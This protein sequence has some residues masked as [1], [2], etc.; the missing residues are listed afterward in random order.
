MGIAHINK[1]TGEIQTVLEHNMNAAEI[2]KKKAIPLQLPNTAYLSAILHDVGKLCVAFTEYITMASKDKHSVRRGS[3][4]HSSAGARFIYD[5]YYQGDAIQKLTAQLMAFAVFS[6]HGLS[7]NISSDGRNFFEDRVHSEKDIHYE[8]VL[9][10][11]EK[12]GM[13]LKIAQEKIPEACREINEIYLKIQKCDSKNGKFYCGVL[14]RILL[15]LV[16]DADRQDT[17]HFMGGGIAAK[18]ECQ[19][20]LWTELQ[21]KFE[22]Y[23]VGFKG[24]TDK[25]SVLRAEISEECY[26]FSDCETGIYCL[27]CP[28]GA[29]KTLASMRFAINH[30]LK[31]GKT[32]IVYVAPF[33]SILEQN[34]EVIRTAVGS[35]DVVLEHHSNVIPENQEEYQFLTE[36]WEA[37]ILATT[38]VQFLDTLFS[39]STQSI[40]RMHSLAQAV[41]II[42]EV[43]SLPV[44]CVHMFN[45]TMNFLSKICGSTII[46]CTAT[47][48]PLE[49]QTLPILLNTPRNMMGQVEERFRQ[50]RRVKVINSCIPGGYDTELLNCFLMEKSQQFRSI[51]IIMNTKKAARDLYECYQETVAENRNEDTL[52][53]HLSANMCP[54]HRMRL[55]EKMRE[56]LGKCQVICISTQLIEAGVDISFD[57]VIRSF[58]G[59]DNIAQAAG[60]CNRNGAAEW[61]Y[62]FI[63]NSADEVL[64]HLPDIRLRQ[65]AARDILKKYTEE[66]EYYGGDLLCPKAMEQFYS[67]YYF[68]EVANMNY[69]I[70]DKERGIK[71]SLMD[72]LSGNQTGM[73][74]YRNEH[75]NGMPNLMLRQAF[76]SAGEYFQVIGSNTTAILVP[77]EE[78]RELIALL[79]G[80]CLPQQQEEALKKAQG[81]TVNVFNIKELEKADAVYQVKCGTYVLKEGFYNEEIG[82]MTESKLDVW[83]V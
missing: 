4:N 77:F 45:L 81:Y 18:E 41:I 72:L 34:A 1:I 42:D 29:G 83:I 35:K 20:G 5:N 76:K 12:E 15:S 57:A 68:S 50:F 56:R 25:L 39:G 7:D 31:K 70:N 36:N 63:V 10:N 16:I 80:N 13:I 9:S 43:Q 53:I 65:D 79:N 73:E 33:C 30:C 27:P 11:I 49:R 47:L 14:Q 8:E 64:M 54:K 3:V 37:P 28:T 22:Q 19:S 55:L 17:C 46:L 61:G 32:R 78:G 66:A 2:A 6:H 82:I 26:Q 40:R 62:L 59:L 71:T 75:E 21:H 51:L 38:M 58:A 67:H 69:S 60:R 74:G 23:M 44:K 52:V 24:W 48:P